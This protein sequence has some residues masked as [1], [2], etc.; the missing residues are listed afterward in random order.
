VL[1][2]TLYADTPPQWVTTVVNRRFFFRPSGLTAIQSR[3]LNSDALAV[4]SGWCYYHSNWLTWGSDRVVECM[5][6]DR[7]GLGIVF[8][9]CSTRGLITVEPKEP[10]LSWC[11]QPP[12]MLTNVIRWQS[13]EGRSQSTVISMLIKLRRDS[14]RSILDS[15]KRKTAL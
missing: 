4:C 9:N 15:F 1:P 10:R 12:Y 7:L 3:R 14:G 11:C 8:G 5:W 13:Q 6:L 2:T